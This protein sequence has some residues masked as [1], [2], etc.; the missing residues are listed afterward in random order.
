LAGLEDD[1]IDT[2]LSLDDLARDKTVVSD[3]REWQL[4]PLRDKVLDGRLTLAA[5]RAALAAADFPARYLDAEVALAEVLAAHA[6]TARLERRSIPDAEKAYIYGLTVEALLRNLYD[7]AAWTKDEQD[8]RLRI[9]DVLRTAEQSSR[10]RGAG[11]ARPAGPTRAE[12]LAQA[13]Y[14]YIE[15]RIT[16]TELRAIYLKLAVPPDRA[17]A[18]IKALRPMRR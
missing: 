11:G 4:P 13:E 2:M 6:K 9:L 18:R 10:D 17:E 7:E 15:G 1:V 16:E 14:D 8:L 3:F 12:M 5:Y